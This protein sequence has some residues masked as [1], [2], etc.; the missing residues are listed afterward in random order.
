VTKPR[1]LEIPAGDIT[2]P[3]YCEGCGQ[4]YVLA[5]FARECAAEHEEERKTLGTDK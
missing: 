3:S 1:D 4:G 2:E 5:Q